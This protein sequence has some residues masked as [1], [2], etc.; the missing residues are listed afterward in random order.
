[1][2]NNIIETRK[3]ILKIL[4]KTDDSLGLTITGL[5][6]ITKLSRSKVRV[7]LAYLM[8]AQSISEKRL[9]MCKLYKISEK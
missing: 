6:E 9:G 7:A 4:K 8:G 5:V 1:M 3:I 2:V